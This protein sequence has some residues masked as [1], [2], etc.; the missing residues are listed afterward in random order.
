M[1]WMVFLVASLGLTT[2]IPWGAS[3]RDSSVNHGFR[4]SALESWTNVVSSGALP[5]GRRDAGVAYDSQGDR[6]VVIGGGG[7]G[8][9][10]WLLNLAGLPTWTSVAEASPP[11]VSGDD[12]AVYDPVN[13]RI[14]LV[15]SS[16]QAWALDLA[17]PTAWGLLAA[18][19]SPPP[20]SFY[21]ATY[22]AL[23]NRLLIFGGGP[24]TG[25]FNDVWALPLSGTSQIWT[26]IVG[27]GAAPAPRWGPVAV[28]DS[29]RDRLIITSGSLDGG[30]SVSNDVWALSLSGTPAWT[31]LAPS[32]SAPPSRMLAAAI[33]DPT[34]DRLLL[35][36][37]YAG[38]GALG[39]VWGLSLQAPVAWTQL[40]PAGTSPPA[41]WSLGAVYRSSLGQMIIFGGAVEGVLND[42][43]ALQIEPKSFRMNRRSPTRLT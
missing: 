29:A 19:S 16:M 36:G 27:A 23:R 35:Y 15:T 11:S 10:T 26:Q 2:S 39:D 7:G 42:T 8:S 34:V 9:A 33:Y 14:I 5:P 32:G 30:Y 18:G 6:L 24:Y 40:S 43:W 20:R 1:R 12:R 41:R 21:A 22:D 38:G 28:Y 31:Q 3:A 4:S 25:L 37:G 17:N 13:N